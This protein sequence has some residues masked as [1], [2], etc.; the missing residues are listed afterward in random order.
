MCSPHKYFRN[1]II[2]LLFLPWRRNLVL[3]K[4]S[5]FYFAVN[6]HCASFHLCLNRIIEYGGHYPICL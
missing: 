4:S 5:I 2:E 6:I 3:I 1:K